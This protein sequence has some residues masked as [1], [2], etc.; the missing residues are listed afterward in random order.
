MIYN[1]RNQEGQWKISSEGKNTDRAGCT[2]EIR[3]SA[4][5]LATENNW[6][7]FGIGMAGAKYLNKGYADTD[8]MLD[9]LVCIE[10]YLVGDKTVYTLTQIIDELKSMGCP[11]FHRFV[12]LKNFHSP[13]HLYN[14]KD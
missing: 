8:I 4:I 1:I 7:Y 12:N 11:Q 2:C 9:Y 13:N 5:K 14:L 3:D 6:K 10:S